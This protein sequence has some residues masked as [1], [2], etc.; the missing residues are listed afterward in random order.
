MDWIPVV[1]I[2][3]YFIGLPIGMYLDEKN[4]NSFTSLAR[5][6][7]EELIKERDKRNV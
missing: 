1:L 4:P 6:M 5:D 2:I 3:L 7:Y